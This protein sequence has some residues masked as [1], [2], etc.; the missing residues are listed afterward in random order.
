MMGQGA[1]M[2]MVDGYVAATIL[3][4]AT[5]VD[6]VVPALAAYDCDVRRTSVNKVIGQS[7]FY[8]NMAVS[9]NRIMCWLFKAMV[10]YASDKFVVEDMKRGDKP[11]KKFVKSIDATIKPAAARSR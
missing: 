7:R 2:A 9:D 5:D 8:G 11:N 6:D 3:E 1:N 10:K 4:A